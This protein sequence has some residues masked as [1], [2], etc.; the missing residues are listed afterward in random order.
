MPDSADSSAP[1]EATDP[2]VVLV[3]HCSFDSGSLKAAAAR[4]LPDAPVVR[5]NTEAEL[6]PYANARHLLLVNR[7]LDGLFEVSTGPELIERLKFDGRSPKMLLISDIGSAQEAAEAAG[8]EPGFGKK[9]VQ[10]DKATD[11]IRAAFPG[12][13]AD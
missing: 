2:H 10:S 3:G 1:A 7:Q 11:R 12:A 9:D 4:A 13:G 5:V 8:A 6:R